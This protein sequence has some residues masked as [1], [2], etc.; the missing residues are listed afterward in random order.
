MRFVERS[1]LKKEQEVNSKMSRNSKKFFSERLVELRGNLSNV[2][3]AKMCGL[4]TPDIQRYVTGKATPTI[5]KLAAIASAY[6]VSSDWLI[7]LSNSK[8]S[9]MVV[10]TIR[11]N[12][13]TLKRAA[14][15]VCADSDT[16][17]KSI[18]ALQEIVK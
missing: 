3:F 15:Q 14:K 9:T 8:E 7:G 16:L 10:P 2:E 13:E 18:N 4:N 17:M 1:I 5:E 11:F 12:V 6:N